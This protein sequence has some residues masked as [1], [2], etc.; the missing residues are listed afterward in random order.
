M[1]YCIAL[2]GSTE[3]AYSLPC[4]QMRDKI[5]PSHSQVTVQRKLKYPLLSSTASCPA[6]AYPIYLWPLCFHE[7][8]FFSGVTGTLRKKDSHLRAGLSKVGLSEVCAIYAHRICTHTYIHTCT[9]TPKHSQW[10]G[11]QAVGT[12]IRLLNSLKAGTILYAFLC[13]KRGIQ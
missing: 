9:P 5:K 10:E 11:L 8:D 12:E 7:L 6:L 1:N 4:K 2:S 13:P 3:N